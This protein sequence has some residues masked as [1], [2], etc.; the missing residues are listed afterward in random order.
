MK[1]WAIAIQLTIVAGLIWLGWNFLRG[2]PS[3]PVAVTAPNLGQVQQAAQN[4]IDDVAASATKTATEIT[5]D[6][7]APP[8]LRAQIETPTATLTQAG[9]LQWTNAA[10]HDNGGLK[11]LTLNAELNAAAEAK[12]QN[13]FSKQYFEHVS[14]SG[15][16][17]GDLATQAGYTFLSEGENLALGNFADDQTLVQA[18]MNSPGHRANILGKYDEIGIAVGRGTYEGNSTWLAVQEFGRPLSACPQLD[19]TLKS[20]VTADKASLAQLTAQADAGRAELDAM[21]KS[22]TQS[23]VDDYNAKVATYNAIVKQ[24]RDLDQQINGEVTVYNGQ[25]QAF[26]A[27]VSQ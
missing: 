20:K 11:A 3:A 25:V 22:Q 10:R 19:E 27:C 6:V 18:W 13:M 21:P 2:Q 5:K 7:T 1:K 15:V 12:L 26:N 9:V 23:Q 8:P 14:P 4:I 17:P 24:I 16:G